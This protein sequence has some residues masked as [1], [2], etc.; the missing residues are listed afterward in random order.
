MQNLISKNYV[1]S[2]QAAEIFGISPRRARERLR[3]LP[4]KQFRRNGPHYWP[5][6]EVEA[7]AKLEQT[8]N[9]PPRVTKPRKARVLAKLTKRKTA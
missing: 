8:F 4:P 3:L 6:T 1:D 2:K 7:M 9:E 5:R